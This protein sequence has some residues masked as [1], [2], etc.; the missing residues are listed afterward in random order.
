MGG[1]IM[2]SMLARAAA[3]HRGARALHASDLS[4]NIPSPRMS[5]VASPPRACASTAPAKCS[6]VSLARGADGRRVSV[7]PGR[8]V[9]DSFDHRD[10]PVVLGSF[11]HYGVRVARDMLARV[12]PAARCRRWTAGRLA[13]VLAARRRSARVCGSGR[14]P[15]AHFGSRP[16]VRGRADTSARRSDRRLHRRRNTLDRLRSSQARKQHPRICRAQ[17]RSRPA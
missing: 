15:R 17:C 12:V 3:C 5:Q 1:M 16:S 8:A 4:I 7:G 10:A 11:D 6:L 14:A 2:V 9:L 13:R